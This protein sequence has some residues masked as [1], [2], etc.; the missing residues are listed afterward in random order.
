[1]PWLKV[2]PSDEGRINTKLYVAL[3]DSLSAG[4][5]ATVYTEKGFV[6]LVHDALGPEFAL[7]NLGIAGD[8]SREMIEEGTLDRAVSGDRDSGTTTTTPAT[9]SRS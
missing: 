7:L 4:V 2:V 8:T 1:M 6:P 5:G 3:G 9:T